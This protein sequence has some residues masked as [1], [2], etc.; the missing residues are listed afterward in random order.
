MAVGGNRGVAGDTG[1]R[2]LGK[3]EGPNHKSYLNC[4]SLG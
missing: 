4:I 1:S 2:G 3:I